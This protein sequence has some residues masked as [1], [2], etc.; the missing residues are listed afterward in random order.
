M[1]RHEWEYGEVGWIW[2]EE[3]YRG[4]FVLISEMSCLYRRSRFLAR[5]YVGVFAFVSCICFSS[6]PSFPHNSMLLIL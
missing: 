5:A 4:I 3:G 1:W 6:L 2:M